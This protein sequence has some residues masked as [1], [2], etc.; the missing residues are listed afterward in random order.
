MAPKHEPI[1]RLINS[2]EDADD[3][4]AEKAA[5]LRPGELA[6]RKGCFGC[7]VGLFA[8]GLPEALA[9]RAAVAALSE[10]TRAAV[11]GRAARLVAASAATFPG[12][13][14]AGV[15]DPDR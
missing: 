7:C 8:I 1:D 5:L 15:L 13:V 12:E 3:L 2:L 6:C 14:A 10:E 11:I 9:L 4:W